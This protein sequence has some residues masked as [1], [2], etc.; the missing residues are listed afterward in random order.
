MEFS[1]G[2]G[3]IDIKSDSLSLDYGGKSVLF[4]G[5]VHAAQAGAQLASDQLRV[6][7]GDNFHDVKE[8]L[9]DGNVRISQGTRWETSDHAVLDQDKHT[10]VLTG[11]PV[12]HDG[13]DQ[14]TGKRIIVHLD[15]G[16]S[17]VEG[18]RAVIFPKQSET[19]N[20]ASADHAQ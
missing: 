12:V 5:H 9:A 2:H 20:A 19:A 17:V 14:I 4:S 1:S 10:V 15:T 11:S 8:M 3:P 13:P 6:N 16:Q 7:Y 18:A